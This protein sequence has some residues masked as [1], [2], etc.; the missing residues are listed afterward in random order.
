M[1]VIKDYDSK[2]KAKDPYKRLD[3]SLPRPYLGMVIIGVAGSGKSNFALNM[4]EWYSP[5]IERYIFISPVIDKDAKLLDMIAMLIDKKKTVK[6]FKNYSKTTIS[7]IERMLDEYPMETMI[8]GDDITG[9]DV[10]SPRNETFTTLMTQRRH[11]KANWVFC[12][13]TWKAIPRKVRMN[14][15]H[16]IIFNCNESEYKEIYEEIGVDIKPYMQYVY[17]KP[18]YS[19]LHVD[20]SSRSPRFSLNM[21]NEL[22]ITMN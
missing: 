20:K 6:T 3:E 5:A 9:Y 2:K 4:V 17:N 19:F 16:F 21:E 22:E 18:K 13:H 15:N 10:V 7:E 8:W 11:F 14:C 12:S 1:P